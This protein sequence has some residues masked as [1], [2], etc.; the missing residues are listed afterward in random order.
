LSWN[1]L[2]SATI[3]TA[4]VPWLPAYLGYGGSLLLQ[5]AVLLALAAWLW[6]G[7]GRE[8]AAAS[9]TDATGSQATTAP[10]I[11]ASFGEAMGRLL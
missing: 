3:A 6:R 8:R 2:Y 9:Q 10:A 1:P 4:P 11:P 5:L 7:F